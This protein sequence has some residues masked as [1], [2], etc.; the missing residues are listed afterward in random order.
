MSSGRTRAVFALRL[1]CILYCGL[2]LAARG[3]A[4]EPAKAAK[5]TSQAAPKAAPEGDAT[6]A[7]QP[8][9]PGASPEKPVFKDEELVQLTAPIALYT[10]DLVSQIL[11]AS[12]YPIEVIEAHRFTEA[13][14]SLKGDALAKALNEK[15]WDASVKSLVNFPTVLKMMNDKLDWMQ[16]LGD[17]FLA[18]QKDVMATIQKLRAMAVEEGNLKS[19]EQ[20]KVS[21]EKVEPPPATAPAGSSSTTTV[22]KI[23]S[24]KPDVIYVPTY[25]PTVVYG[26]YP[27]PAYPP[28]Y[29]TPPGYVAAASMISFGVGVACGAAWGHA[30]GNCNWGGG[31]VDIDVNK[32]VNFNNNINR[33]QGNRAGTTSGGKS[34]WQH[35]ASHRKGA[36]YRDQGTAQKYG[37]GA[38]ASNTQAR[39]SYRGRA[40]Q[41]RQNLSSP[42][43]REAA[44]K[45]VSASD[46]AGGAGGKGATTRNTGGASNR[47]AGGASASTRQSGGGSGKSSAFGGSGSSGKQASTQSSRGSSSRSSASRSSSGGSRSSGSRGGGGRSGGGRGGGGRR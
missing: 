18:Q 11:M 3:E 43:S 10:D 19:N 25:N 7:A 26:A 6:K 45:S 40:E 36:G 21:T 15:T 39:D 8:A 22:I 35:D 42:S 32:N 31:D 30:W 16:K 12:T 20:Q 34:S 13:N 1:A 44:S 28:Y 17:A 47:G 33:Q 4:Q 38:S 37:K 2:H 14:K 9:A 41:G 5:G 27:Y 23:E 29:Y 46:R 24:S